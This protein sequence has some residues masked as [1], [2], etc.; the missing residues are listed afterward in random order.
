MHVATIDPLQ[1]DKPRAKC[2][3]P[4]LGL[5]IGLGE[6]TQHAD[7]PRLLRLL[8]AR[9]DR[10]H[11]CSSKD[12]CEI[13]PSHLPAP[14][15]R[16]ATMSIT[17]G[18]SAPWNGANRHLCAAAIRRSEALKWSKPTSRTCQPGVGLYP[19][20]HRRP[21]GR[22]LSPKDR[23]PRSLAHCRNAV[24]TSPDRAYASL[25]FLSGSVRTGFPVAAWIA[26]RTAGVTTQIVG[27]P[28]PPQ[29]S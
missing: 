16:L 14:S 19:N 28:T 17:A 1:F 23:H 12:F 25:T 18:N 6:R 11:D 20:S 27:S 8:R 7:V 10:P 15:S 3:I 29:K 2:R 22:S 26:L 24:I 5:G 13:P 21:L 9:R 4:C